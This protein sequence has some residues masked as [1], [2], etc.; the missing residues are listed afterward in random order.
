MK[1]YDL[2]ELNSKVPEIKYGMQKKILKLSE[3]NPEL[4][5]DDFDFFVKLLENSNNILLWTGILVLGNLAK[6]DTGNKI[7]EI[8]P[9]IFSKLNVGKMITAGNTIKSLVEIAKAKPKL[10]DKIT[11]E[12]M[13]VKDYK[14]DTKECAD[15]A[16]GH[17]LKNL[18]QIWNLL[19][20]DSKS[21]L[22]KFAFDEL[23]N[24]RP[25]T[26]RKAEHLLSKYS[27]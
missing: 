15:I 21:L 8:L 1:A 25:A 19:N 27:S 2:S 23:G 10:A 12:I 9:Q 16:I 20:N 24:S 3:T 6:V 22:L 17:A 4:L 13:R 11:F 5:Y 18:E 14:Y 7:D 26:A